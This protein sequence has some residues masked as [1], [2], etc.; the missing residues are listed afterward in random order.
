MVRSARTQ[1][2]LLWG[3]ILLGIFAGEAVRRFYSIELLSIPAILITLLITLGIAA[4][5]IGLLGFHLRKRSAAS[6]IKPSEYNAN[7]RPFETELF[8]LNQELFTR[9]Q[10]QADALSRLNIELQLQM[11]MSKQAE[12]AVRLNEERFRNMADNIQEG[13]T[14]LENGRLVYLNQR[15][16]EI[17]GDCP[18]GNLYDRIATFAA[19][20][21]HQRIRKEI[22]RAQTTGTAPRELEYWILRKDGER[23]YVREWYAANSSNETERI[24]IVTS[25]VTETKQ[26]YQ[27]LEN[28]VS[29]RTREL[30]TVLDVSQRIASTLAL[31]PLLD[32][33]LEQIQTVIP[34]IGVALFSL[35]DGKFEA[36]AYRVPGL[37]PQDR[38]LTL[39][40]ER[41][42]AYARVVKKKKV[43]I[44]DD[45]RGDT[46]L[47]RAFK[48]TSTH[49]NEF[50]FDHARSWIGIPLIARDSVT[51]LLSLAH[52]QPNFY[53]QRH[54]RI[55]TTIANQVAIAIEN[56]RL[57]EQA[58]SLAVIEERHRI[59]RELHD[60]VTQLLYGI[61]LYC[62]ATSRSI[63][64]KNPN[65][66][67]QNLSTIKENALQALQ[68]MR[69]LILELDPPMLQKS[70]LVDALRT[71]LDVIETRT[72]LETELVANGINRLP[73]SMETELYRIALEALNNL[74]RHARARKVT[75]ELTREWNS[76]YMEIRDNGIGFD[77]EEAIH[78]GGMGLHNMEQ[79]AKQ[80]GGKID[81]QSRPG[82][83]TS[84]QII[85][86]LD[87]I[88]IERGPE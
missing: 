10:E 57:Y 55:A 17:F 37:P 45:I 54:A 68:E 47:S 51:G 73:R 11:A 33:I 18:D 29:D 27:T 83:G 20:E 53:T 85:A 21:E 82:G 69:L 9:A 22:H 88:R 30:S 66:I 87:K 84:I 19:P 16:C 42:E 5:A 80:I 24:F 12:E 49:P 28:A 60:S 56:A 4:I 1:L 43:I 58:Q 48:D 41:A 39:T 40:L 2:L 86:P 32:L 64:S 31:E 15:T 77:L 76:V 25:D 3:C 74:I 78:S 6:S 63:R 46:P 52:N 38:P 70:G 7:P 72:G 34:Y 36:V 35:A 26:A 79:R 62:T 67:E 81:I 71:S 14:I 75:V 65:N 50:S 23:R 13:L 44:I 61:T 8:Q 59:A